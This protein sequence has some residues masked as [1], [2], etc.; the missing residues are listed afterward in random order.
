MTTCTV[1]KMHIATR[2]LIVLFFIK[3]RATTNNLSFN[4]AAQ[5]KF[6]AL[7]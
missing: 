6:K 3:S 2:K 1:N 4:S 5:I 7:E